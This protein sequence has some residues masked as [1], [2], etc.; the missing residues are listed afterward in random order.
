MEVTVLTCEFSGDTNNQPVTIIFYM[1]HNIFLKVKVVS[2]LQAEKYPLSLLPH[3]SHSHPSHT[4]QTAP[5]GKQS[6]FLMV[7]HV[8]MSVFCFAQM[9]KYVRICFPY[10]IRKSNHTIDAFCAF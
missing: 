5:V 7:F 3:L 4:F 6:H 1:K 9:S 2:V 10:F 8:C